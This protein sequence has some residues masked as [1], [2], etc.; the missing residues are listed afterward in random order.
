MGTWA[1][2]VGFWVLGLEMQG[3][4]KDDLRVMRGNGIRGPFKG[5]PAKSP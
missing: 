4:W 5:A 2:R 3:L 1:S